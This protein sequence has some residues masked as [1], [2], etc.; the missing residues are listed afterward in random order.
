M[1]SALLHLLLYFLPVLIN[2]QDLI[3]VGRLEQTS[4]KG[5]VVSCDSDHLNFIKS[6]SGDTSVFYLKTIN[7]IVLGPVDEIYV[8]EFKEDFISGKIRTIGFDFMRYHDSK[9]GVIN[10]IN[11]NKI[12]ACQ[13]NDSCISEKLQKYFSEYNQIVLEQNFANNISMISKNGTIVKI[14]NLRFRDSVILFTIISGENEV[15]SYMNRGNSG[16]IYF[17][18]ESLKPYLKHGDDFILTREGNIYAECSVTRITK[19]KVF[20]TSAKDAAMHETSA[21]KEKICALLFFN[22]EKSIYNSRAK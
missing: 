14:K 12:F 19:D 9:T 20:F 11:K 10:N 7:K 15:S 5:R 4:F 16:T 17:G 13:F 18:G 3:I 21:Q 2:A 1:K 8:N 22:F 6:D